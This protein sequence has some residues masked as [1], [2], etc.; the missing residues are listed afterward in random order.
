[1]QVSLSLVHL[2][3]RY[4]S[5]LLDTVISSSHLDGNDQIGFGFYL[6]VES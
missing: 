4:V 3:T 1:M 5:L 6:S 2:K